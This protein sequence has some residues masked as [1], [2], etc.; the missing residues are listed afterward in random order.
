MKILEREIGSIDYVA[1]QT[2][3]L[4]LP[5]NYA[6]RALSLKLE[7]QLDVDATGS[8]GTPKDSCPAQLVQN[9][10]IR[11]NGRDVIKNY[12]L[13]TLHR[14]TQMRYKTRP[15]VDGLPAGFA[16]Q[17]DMEVDVH[18]MVDFAMWDAI[19][20]IDTLLDSSGLST[21]ELI[22]TFGAANDV[23]TDAYDGVVSVDSATLYVAA[24]ESV[25]VPAGTKFMVN[26]E[27][28]LR[29]Q[30]NAAS[31]RHQIHLPV[32]N[33]YRSFVLKTHS[34]GCNVNTILNNI[35]LI[36]GTEVFKNRYAGFLQM[37]NRVSYQMENSIACDTVD[38]YYLERLLDG[39]YILE[40]VKDGR[41]T[42]CLDTS[43]L[44]GLDLILDVNVP[45]TVDIIDVYPVE[46]VAPASAPAA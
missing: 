24:I 46:L 25:G 16:T 28:S 44:S 15:R 14:L 13:E 19:R 40:F 32:S 37:D 7:A 17:T 34:D 4:Q 6:Y 10:Q 8:A 30:V 12:D 1:N 22:V 23:M 9:I 11:A 39:Y 36:S 45:G 5:R 38:R 43:K 31:D 18:A 35:Q 29:S 20:P 21:L 27:Y 2:R 3:T 41:L 42:E 33:L 26:K